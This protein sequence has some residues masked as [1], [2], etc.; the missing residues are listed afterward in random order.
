MR[1]TRYLGRLG[2]ALTVAAAL[3]LSAC[4]SE[5][6]DPGTSGAD[7]RTVASAYGDVEVPAQPER[8]VAVSYDTPWQ[9][10]SL[11]VKPVATQDYGTWVDSF[12]P[13]QQEFVKGVATVGAFGET[14]YDAIVKAAPD[15]IVGDAYEIDEKAY[16]RLADIAP[17]VIVKGSFRGDWKA[18]M[19]G[20]AEATGAGDA[21]AE[22][23]EAYAAK[24]A[25]LKERYADQLALTWATVS[26]G[27]AEAEF[28]VLYPTGTVGALL[29]ELGATPAPGIPDASPEPGYA[30][31]SFERLDAIL[32]TADVIVVPA[33]ADGTPWEPFAVIKSNSLFTALP[34][35]RSGSV[36][37]LSYG[38][39][40]YDTAL[41]FLDDVETTILE[42]L[43]A[44]S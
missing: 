20:L 7:T 15:L 27:D 1:T 24:V 31:Y 12:T 22:R 21:L 10:Q 13:A 8:V 18:I 34:A 14:N 32:S 36:F 9:L 19:A 38:V 35:A 25:G 4:G 26:V 43:A 11:D 29:D 2:V 28:S 6:D 17:T 5:D 41:Q 44:R 40:D 37:E 23:E 42:P 16:E 39:T 30:S 33:N 3:A